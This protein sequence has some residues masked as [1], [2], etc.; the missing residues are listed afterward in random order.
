MR[1]QHSSIST[2]DTFFP[3]VMMILHA[4]VMYSSHR[5]RPARSPV[6]SSRRARSGVGAR[7]RYSAHD[8]R[9]ADHQLALLIGIGQT[10]VRPSYATT[11]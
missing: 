3:A 5:R 7:S 2:G 11:T 4:A 9:A 1:A 8:C 6:C 10:A